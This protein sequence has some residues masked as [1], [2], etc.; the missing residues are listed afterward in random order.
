VSSNS[1]RDTIAAIGNSMSSA[2]ADAL[3]ETTRTYGKLL[4]TCDGEQRSLGEELERTNS[5]KR[6][7]IEAWPRNPPAQPVK[8]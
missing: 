8:P 5:E 3:R 6:S 2:T 1:L 4:T 7:L